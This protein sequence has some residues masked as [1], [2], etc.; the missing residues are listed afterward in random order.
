[1]TTLNWRTARELR[2]T[3]RLIPDPNNT[4]E[5]LARFNGVQVA[6]EAGWLH[7]DPRRVGEPD[8]NVGDPEFDVFT[9]PASSVERI[10]FREAKGRRPEAYSG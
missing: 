2:L 8:R 9:V 1:M 4:S 7:I 5:M 6:L 10:L 3:D